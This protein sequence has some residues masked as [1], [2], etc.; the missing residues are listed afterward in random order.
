MIKLCVDFLLV[1]KKV[2]SI[3]TCYGLDGPAFEAWWGGEIFQ[4]HAD[5]P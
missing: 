5:R 4:T 2:V 1:L 3:A